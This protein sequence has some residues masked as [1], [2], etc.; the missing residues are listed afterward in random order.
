MRPTITLIRREFNAYFNSPIAYVVIVAFLLG[1]G[2]LFFL[3]FDLLTQDGP[4]GVEWPMQSMLG[5]GYFWLPFLVIPAVLTM[6]SF[7]E[8]RGSGTLE[9][10]LTAPLRDWQVVLAKYIACFAFY[11]VLWLPTLA[12]LPILLNYNF[13]TNEAKIDPWPVLTTYAGLALAGAMFLALG[14]FISSLVK[15]QLVAVLMSMVVSIVF[16]AAAFARPYMETSSLAYRLVYFFSVPLHF[17]SDFTRGVIDSRHLILY[18]S[19]A[20]FFLFMTVR[21]LEAR[22]WR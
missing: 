6:R 2:Y 22:R 16:V 13:G 19:V 18:G 12:Y 8:E 10:L 9:M 7:A 5:S 1:T 15:S 14:L 3:T 11:V 21:S 4:V 17:R 20:L